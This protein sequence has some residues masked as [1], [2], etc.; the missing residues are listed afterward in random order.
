MKRIVLAIAFVCL[1]V[2]APA[3]SPS[4]PPAT[5]PAL[6][7]TWPV[8]V[9]SAPSTWTGGITWDSYTCP[10]AGACAFALYR[11]FA[12]C[13]SS[14]A[15]TLVAQGISPVPPASDPNPPQPGPTAQVAC[16]FLVSIMNG[17]ESAPSNLLQVQIPAVAGAVPAPQNLGP[18]MNAE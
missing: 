11:K 5:W 18:A 10:T 6:A 1:A 14:P 8:T 16:Y 15:F 7:N 4:V 17:V 13:H 3:Q 2:A 12:D 9:Y